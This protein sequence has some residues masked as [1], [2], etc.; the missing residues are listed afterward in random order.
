MSVST[1]GR[2]NTDGNTRIFVDDSEDPPPAAGTDGDGASDVSEFIAGTNPDDRLSNLRVE[3]IARAPGGDLTIQWQ[4]VGG[5]T[6]ILQASTT[7]Q[8][9]EWTTVS[10]GI[11]AAGAFTC[12]TLPFATSHG[13]FRVI[14]E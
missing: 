13:F 9:G 7:L 8:G 1:N 3:E 5:K 14:V 6:Y 12:Y 4:S 10:I 11:P 2:D